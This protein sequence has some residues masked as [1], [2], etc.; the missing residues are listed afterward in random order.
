VT[1][2]RNVPLALSISEAIGSLV[3]VVF[4]LAGIGWKEYCSPVV[5]PGTVVVLCESLA[6]VF[7]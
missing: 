7:Q 4:P 5:E 6:H 1:L 2:S 3:Q